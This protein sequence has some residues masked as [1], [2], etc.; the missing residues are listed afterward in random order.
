MKGI[1]EKSSGCYQPPLL[2]PL[3]PLTYATPKFVMES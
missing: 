3:Y 2:P 1:I